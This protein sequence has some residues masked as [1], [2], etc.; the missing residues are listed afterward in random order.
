M[1]SASQNDSSDEDFID[2]LENELEIDAKVG[3]SIKASNVPLE[4]LNGTFSRGAADSR[5]AKE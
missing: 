3:D 2:F 1:T 5:Y 4:G